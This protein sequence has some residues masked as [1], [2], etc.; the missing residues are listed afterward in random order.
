MEVQGS[1]STTGQSK[2]SKLPS[3]TICFIRFFVEIRVTTIPI[4]AFIRNPSIRFSRRV[5]TGSIA[6]IV[7][8]IGWLVV[9]R[10]PPAGVI[11][12]LCKLIKIHCPPRH[13]G[14]SGVPLPRLISAQ[15]S[16][17]AA[18]I[19]SALIIS[20]IVSTCSHWSRSGLCRRSVG[21]RVKLIHLLVVRY[22]PQ[23][24]VLILSSAKCFDA[25]GFL[26]SSFVL[27]TLQ[28]F[29]SRRQV[30]AA[31]FVGNRGCRQLFL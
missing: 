7:C 23:T 13:L 25:V 9:T 30:S 22:G 29:L 17:T 2:K 18:M 26:F 16:T 12:S 4:A 19:I 14:I 20:L 15:R 8:A 24:T 27:F 10:D 21:S 3:N 5:A 1:K 6:V 28:D 31:V 11:K